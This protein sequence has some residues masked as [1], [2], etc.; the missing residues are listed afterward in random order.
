MSDEASPT[1]AVVSTPAEVETA[2]PEVATAPG[3]K[4]DVVMKEGNGDAEISAPKEVATEDA[5][6][7]SKNNSRLFFPFTHK[8]V[9]SC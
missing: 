8:Q 4:E 1:A 6:A 2:R 9:L 5:P 3:A 7:D